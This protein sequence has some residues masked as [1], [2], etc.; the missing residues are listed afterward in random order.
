M[1][2]PIT[3]PALSPT[4]TEGTLSKWLKKE[5]DKV[6]SGD[7]LAEIET[8][9]AS[10][11]VE[12]VDEG[13]L[14]RI[15]VQEGTEN[16]P[17]NQPIAL[18]LE[19]GEDKSALDKA[20]VAAAP[21]AAKPSAAPAPAAKEAAHAPA[22]KAPPAAEPAP[23]PAAPAAAAAGGRVFASPLAR[24][25]AEEAGLDLSTVFGSGPHGRIVKEDVETA[26]KGGA[27]RK[28]AAPAPRGTAAPAAPP[29]HGGLHARAYADRLGMAY[30]LVPNNNIRK[31]I[32]RRLTESVQTVP[33][34]MLTVEVEIDRL[35]RIRKEIAADTELKISVNDFVIKAAA[36]A[37]MKVPNANASW[38][39]EGVLLYEQA[40]ISVAVATDNGLIT[41]I[42]KHA[43]AK[44]LAA[45]SAE[46]KDLATRAKE[47]KL[48]P[49]EFLGGTFSVSNLGMFG[50]QSFTSI[51]NPPQACILSVGA[52]EKRPVVREGDKIEVAT[53]MSCTMAC[54][55][56]VVDGALGAEL[57]VALKKLLES[58]LQLMV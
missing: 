25:L 46:V 22:A 11:E 18:L 2:I 42:V 40:D 27:P 12:A 49:E 52:G 53:R 44:S 8:D 26:R 33:H 14:G 36:L 9:K 7:V 35:L 30:T 51:I 28:A 29:A 4:M 1:P 19:E 45:I 34:Y 56:R 20:G 58:P 31:T 5:G 48:K 43:N 57:L 41:P 10:M 54:D 17:V 55:H 39:D 38:S 23:K 47:G 3:M 13:I 21:P 37:L 16:V 24:R 15:L 50:I 6:K 32:A